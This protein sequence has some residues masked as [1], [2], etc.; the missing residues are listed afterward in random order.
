VILVIFARFAMP[1]GSPFHVVAG[2]I[3]CAMVLFWL[4]SVIS[5]GK[6]LTRLSARPSQIA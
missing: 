1:G 4:L 3:Q 6:C 5:V 2:L